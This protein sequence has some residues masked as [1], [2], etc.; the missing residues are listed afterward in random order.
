VVGSHCR[1]F[2]RHKPTGN[3]LQSYQLVTESMIKVYGYIVTADEGHFDKNGQFV[4]DRRR[5]GD[6]IFR[7]GLWVEEDTGV[8]RVITCE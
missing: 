2:L 6:E 7:R 5:N 1:V 8:L 4:A 3:T